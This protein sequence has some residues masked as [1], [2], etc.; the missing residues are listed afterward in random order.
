MSALEDVQNQKSFQY[1]FEVETVAQD[2][3][4]DKDTKLDLSNAR[5]KFRE[6]LRALEGSEDRR[7]WMQMGSVYIERPTRECK[8]ILKN[9]LANADKDIQ[10]LDK[11]IKNKLHKL[12]DLEHEPRLEGFTLKPISAAEA[13]TLHKAFGLL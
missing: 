10:E 4:T 3:L 11:S 12:R 2:I 5:N 9:E 13:K 6:A 1:L 7:T 8:D